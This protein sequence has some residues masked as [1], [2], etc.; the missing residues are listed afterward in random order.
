MLLTLVKVQ[1]ISDIAQVFAV[2]ERILGLKYPVATF[3]L[4][5]K[6][7]LY[8]EVIETASEVK[9]NLNVPTSYPSIKIPF[10]THCLQITSLA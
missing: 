2:G 10:I 7:V 5:L 3:Q 6:S 4:V 1:I 8:S 9:L